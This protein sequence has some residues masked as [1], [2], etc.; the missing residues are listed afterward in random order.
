MVAILRDGTEIKIGDAVT[1]HFRG[2]EGY[3]FVICG[4]HPYDTCE[5]KFMV[6]AHLKGEPER[7]IKSK[8][9]GRDGRPPGIDANWFKLVPHES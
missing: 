8:F 7:K 1:T 3:E 6:E 9:A 5:S 2:C 4:I